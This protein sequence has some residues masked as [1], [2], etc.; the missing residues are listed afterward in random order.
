MLNLRRLF[1]EKDYE[2]VDMV[3]RRHWLIPFA[4]VA[5]FLVELILPAA[6]VLVFAPN[7]NALLAHP[8]LGPGL[9]LIASAYILFAWLLF[10]NNFVDYYLDVWIVTNE[11][12]TNVE[13]KG[14]FAR[15]VSETRFF[16]VQDVTSE[17]NGILA[18]MFGYGE[19]FIQTAGTVTRLQMKQVPRAHD[20]ARRILELVEKDRPYH[21]H[22]NT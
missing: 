2:R 16:R 6:V 5:L 18:T 8:V 11:R 21:E 20:V 13:Q 17:V 4:Y 9:T 19:V 3:L 12:I 22:K 7:V 10:F 1:G 14:L 15:T